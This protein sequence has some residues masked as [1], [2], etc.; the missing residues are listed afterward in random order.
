MQLLNINVNIYKK[1]RLKIYKIN[2]IECSALH[3]KPANNLPY[4]TYKQSCMRNLQTFHPS[5]YLSVYAF[6][7]PL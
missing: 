5:T 2:E 6:V 4:E 7:L 1:L 3:T